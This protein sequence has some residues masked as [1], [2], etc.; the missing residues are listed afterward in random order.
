[1]TKRRKERELAG[2]AIGV[3]DSGQR[4]D[5]KLVALFESAMVIKSTMK[6]ECT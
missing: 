1:M 2:G 3:R 4:E 6:W 5:S